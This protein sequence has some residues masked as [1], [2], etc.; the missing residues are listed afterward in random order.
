MRRADR[1]YVEKGRGAS[2]IRR[3]LRVDLVEAADDVGSLEEPPRSPGPRARRPPAASHHPQRLAGRALEQSVN[4]YQGCEHGCIYCFARPVALV[5]ETGRGLRLETRIFHKPGLAQ[6][7]ARELAAPATCA[8]RSTSAPTPT[9]T[10]RE[11]ELGTHA[12]PAR[13]PSAAPA[14]GDNR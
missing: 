5:L 2:P 14:P 13:D 8:S 12:R 1:Q 4:P 9:P 10:S 3:P 7:L 11:R 6:L